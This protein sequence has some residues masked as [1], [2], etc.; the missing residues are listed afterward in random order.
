MTDQLNVKQHNDAVLD[1]VANAIRITKDAIEDTSEQGLM[2]E[3]IRWFQEQLER[4][5]FA[6]RIVY[7]VNEFNRKTM[8]R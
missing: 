4:E 2:L 3:A 6:N 1:A 5:L 8:A 7:D